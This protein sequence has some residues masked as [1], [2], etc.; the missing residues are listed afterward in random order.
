MGSSC[1]ATISESVRHIRGTGLI[2]E[3]AAE[4]NRLLRELLASLRRGDVDAVRESLRAG[5]PAGACD[6]HGWA[7]LHYSASAGQAEI[8]RLLLEHRGDPN[9]TL[10]DLSTPL[11]LA[12]EEAHLSV[13]RLLLAEGAL[14]KCKDEDGF[15]ALGRCD[16]SVQEDFRR[17]ISAVATEPAG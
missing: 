9:A 13:A 15:T 3:A 7:P 2:E 14:T 10:P 17:L 1:S 8:S 4:R 5:A 11:M 6:E 16:P 12:V